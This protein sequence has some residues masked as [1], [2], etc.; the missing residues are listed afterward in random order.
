M[1][2]RPVATAVSLGPGAALP[3]LA[4]RYLAEYLEKIRRAV[5][6]LDDDQ[7]WWRPAAN[8]NAIGNLLLHLA[9]NLSLWIA[10]SLGGD[11]FERDRSGEFAADRSHDGDE[12]IERLT[13]VVTRCC[14]VLEGLREE[15]LD[16]IVEVQTY[17]ADTLGII[18]HAV[19]HMAYHTG[20]ILFIAKQVR[21][22]DH[23]IEFYPQHREE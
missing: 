11:D 4:C 9:G 12:M 6:A 20:Q 14:Q 2:E 8:T 16:R 15:P 1:T 7:I 17:R 13:A 3:E 23:G 5:A 18:V 10:K 19:E 21:G 22:A